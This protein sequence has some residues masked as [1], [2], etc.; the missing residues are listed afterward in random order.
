MSNKGQWGV[1]VVPYDEGHLATS[2]S[3]SVL[4]DETQVR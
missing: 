4:P 3:E 2:E 1:S